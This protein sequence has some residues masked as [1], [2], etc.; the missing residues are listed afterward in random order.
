M[1]LAAMIQQSQN[2]LL[3]ILNRQAETVCDREEADMDLDCLS[4]DIEY[5]SEAIKE[6]QD[7]IPA[8]LE[9]IKT[10]K[11]NK[12]A[13]MTKEL[14]IAIAHIQHANICSDDEF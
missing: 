13:Y 4:Q 14:E 12:L 5:F 7:A 6:N 8:A 3:N 2:F 9:L 11:D 1:Q 10:F